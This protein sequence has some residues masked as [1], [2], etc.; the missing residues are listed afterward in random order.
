MGARNGYALHFFTSYPIKSYGGTA[1]YGPL[2]YLLYI[3]YLRRFS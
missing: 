2:I 3:A 1:I